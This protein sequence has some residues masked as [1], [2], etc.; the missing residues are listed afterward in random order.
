MMFVWYGIDSDQTFV[1]GLLGVLTFYLFSSTQYHL[2]TNIFN[3][4]KT[5]VGFINA[6]IHVEYYFFVIYKMYLVLFLFTETHARH[7]GVFRFSFI[8]THMHA[9]HQ[10]CGCQ[11]H[12]LSQGYWTKFFP[13]THVRD[14]QKIWM[15]K[16]DKWLSSP[17]ACTC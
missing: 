17:L 5:C 8:F 11:C 9:R 10:V 16:N 1:E 2:K 14:D 13:Q 6:T 15:P 3:F 7:Q 4:F 12:N